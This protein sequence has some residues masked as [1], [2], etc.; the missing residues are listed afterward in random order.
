MTGYTAIVKIHLTLLFILFCSNEAYPSDNSRLDSIEQ[1]IISSDGV[2]RCQHVVALFRAFENQENV[3]SIPFPDSY[4]SYVD[5]CIPLAD[6]IDDIDLLNSL[7]ISRAAL[8]LRESR[9]LEVFNLMTEVL[10][11]QQPLDIY[12]SLDTYVFLSNACHGLNLHDKALELAPVKRSI[13][14][15]LNRQDVINELNS[16]I[17]ITYYKLG[18]FDL[19]AFHFKELIDTY[20][21]EENWYLVASHY[22]NLGLSYY[23]WEKLDSALVFYDLAKKFANR[24]YKSVDNVIEKE[25]FLGFIDGHIGEAY[26]GMDSIQR[27]IELALKDIQSSKKVNQ[28]ENVANRLMLIS[29][30]YHMSNRLSKALIYLEEAKKLLI[31]KGL[32]NH[33]KQ[34]EINNLKAQLLFEV[35]DFKLSAE[36]YNKN[37][38]LYDSLMVKENAM[39]A[40]ISN[41]IFQVY[42]KENELNKQKVNL[43][44][45]ET[46]HL[47]EVQIRNTLFLI[48]L[49]L[50]L[51]AALGY[52]SQSQKNR[53]NKLLAEQKIE[54]ENQKKEIEKNLLEKE[55]LL[56]EI[57]HRVKNNLQVISGMFQLQAGASKSPEIVSIMQEGNDRIQA[58]ALIHQQ[59]YQ[60]GHNL[61]D[62]SFQKYLVKLVNNIASTYKSKSKNVCIE[63]EAKDAQLD[64]N[65]AIPLGLIINE[66]VSNAF[67]YAFTGESNEQLHISVESKGL[68]DF[69]LVVSDNGIGFPDGF[70]LNKINSLGLK[71]VKILSKQLNG[72]IH[73]SSDEG[74]SFFI[75][76]KNNIAV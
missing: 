18:V 72:S 37:K 14:Q 70:D 25:Y 54:I 58:M 34:M 23:G 12:D 16:E 65:T 50:L 68:N 66:L 27:G 39:N 53:A 31:D 41:S 9:N 62:I 29:Q 46:K 35:K 6:S 7:K 17:A 38:E 55:I 20:K 74:C 19:A 4:Y 48:A 63:I 60:N 11:S 32:F 49:G 64:V 51:F 75:T 10:V 45:I 69:L 67:K 52:L 76:F 3:G 24:H 26:I 59:L 21:N 2:T 15:K 33:K 40:L 43:A 8:L 56:K 5:E 42:Q 71:L 44:I 57:Q 1:L 73:T 13:A 30:A 22:G 28:F 47:K 61:K 36:L